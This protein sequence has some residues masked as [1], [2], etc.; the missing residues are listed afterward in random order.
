MSD[1]A[2]RGSAFSGSRY[3]A[4]R[5]RQEIV[6]GLQLDELDEEHVKN[7]IRQELD[8]ALGRDGG[9]L[10]SDR[11]EAL[12]FYHGEPFGNEVPDRSQVVML[13]VLEAVEW[14]LPAL[15][16]IFTA[17]DK[18]CLIEPPP[19]QQDPLK[20]PMSLQQQMAEAEAMAKHATEYINHIFYKDN[21]GFLLL[22]DWFKDALLE[23]L[24]WVKY[25]W[26][27]QRRSET[28]SYT[29]L[30]REQ[31]DA[32]LGGDGEVEVT[33]LERYEQKTDSFNRDRPF[34][35][36]PAPPM[37]PSGPPATAAAL[38]AMP[39]G[40]P[41][42]LPGVPGGT[43]AMSPAGPPPPPGALPL[44]LSMPMMVP[45]P[46]PPVEL[47]DCTLRITSEVRQVKI[48]NVPPE[49]ILFS[50]QAKRGE[51]PFI[52]HRRRW[53]Y[54]DLIQ[55][56]YDEEC[57]DLVP[58]DDSAEYSQERIERHSEDGDWPSNPRPKGDPGHDIWVEENYAYFNVE[59]GGKT[60]ELYKV[61][62]AGNGLVI[63]TK[64]GKPDVE[65]VEEM[66]FVSICP[67]PASHK[68]VGKS[69]ADLT[70]DLQLI[71]STLIRQQIDNAF[72][73][74]WPRIEVADDVVN[75]NT[76]DDLLT[77]RPGGVLRTRRVG[78]I[79]P[80]TIPFTADKTFPLVA[81]IDKVAQLRT[82]VSAEGQ[83][84]SADALNNTAA[85]SIA[86]LQQ[87]AA[88]RIELFARIFA[89]GV[90]QL[91]RGVMRLVRRHQQQE[92][93]IRVTGGWL[94]VDPKSWRHDMP[95]TV[96]VGLGSGNRDQILQHLMQILQ[97][98]GTIVQQQQG[99]QGPLVY[100]Q[101][102]YDALQALQENAGFKSSFF[103]DPSK[104]PPPQAG[105]P[106]PPPKPD[107]E[108]MKAQAKIQQEQMQAQAN[109][110][111]IGAKAQ[112]EER[113]MNE[114]AQM[115]AAIQQQKLDHE[116]Q[117]GLLRAQHELELER[118]KAEN[119][120]AVGMAKVKIAG[121]AKQREIELK[122][123]AGAYDQT[124]RGPANGAGGPLD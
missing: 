18:I 71:K 42:G 124:P 17:S 12:R 93:I 39:A 85:S 89:H 63:L 15:I 110:Q 2:Y 23:K 112:A 27:T 118:Q 51:V 49:E 76:Y 103:A 11:L 5:V 123:A 87:S 24:G 41:P 94:N 40:L 16:R 100:A 43:A 82:G 53:T 111:A 108:M 91:M 90:E 74:N 4:P 122:Y 109:V 92:R 35:P 52:S 104:P 113:L 95:V 88:Q 102:V 32:I 56:G 107:P 101:N 79:Q 3:E 66:P 37:P 77:L 38:P 119:N 99:V 22:H 7:V 8:S 80:M 48:V 34:V 58:W 68:L 84:I 62:T 120:L 67:I 21:E 57:L 73:T 26:D 114:K 19:P 83:M 116:K 78:G 9:Q 54:S 65:C 55:Q 28:K 97:L 121:E 115:D 75:E 70:M 33:K 81:Y 30:T 20:P 98:Q 117:M 29:G 45:L 13:T 46:P 106:P 36:P 96:S 59:E 105:P 31:Y 64:D 61:V 6:Q 60:T 25:Y 44:G 69:L 10:S 47:Y 72:L 14:V 1:L 50:R 86:M